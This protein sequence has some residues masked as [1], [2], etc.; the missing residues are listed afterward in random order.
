MNDF[1]VEFGENFKPT[2]LT[3]VELLGGL[4]EERFERGVVC[5][6]VKVDSKKNV[7]K[8]LAGIYYC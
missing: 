8:V 3:I 1:K 4:V 6:N 7:L 2:N 5:N